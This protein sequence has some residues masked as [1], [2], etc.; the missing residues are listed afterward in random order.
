MNCPIC[1]HAID[2]HNS[3]T[4]C[5]KCC[6]HGGPC[7]GFDPGPWPEPKQA[8]RYIATLWVYGNGH[9]TPL[10]IP[11]VTTVGYAALRV[12]TAFGL[13]PYGAIYHLI[14]METG[15]PLDP[16]HLVAQHDGL[17]VGLLVC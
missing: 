13:D 10:E 16:N 3:A 8:D 4:T 5:N 9:P 11:G 14:A 12:A 7:S 15:Q 2:D 17:H 1:H 6:M